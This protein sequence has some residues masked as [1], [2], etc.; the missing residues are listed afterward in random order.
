MIKKGEITLC[1]AISNFSI[2]VLLSRAI[3][4]KT[5]NVC[6]KKRVHVG[7]YDRYKENTRHTQNSG[8]KR[9]REKK[10]KKDA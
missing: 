9:A 7:E 1:Y 3:F 4:V 8:G 6:T 5:L 2:N 10:N